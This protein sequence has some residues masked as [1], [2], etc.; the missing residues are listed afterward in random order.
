MLVRDRAKLKFNEGSKMNKRYF[1]AESGHG[2]SSS[3]GFC[4]DTVVYCFTSKQARDEYVANNK[5]ISCKSIPASQATK[6]ATNMSLTC[7][8]TNA[9]RP[10]SGEFWTIRNNEFTGLPV[11]CI[12][13]V[14]CCT[15]GEYGIVERFYK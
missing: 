12:G 13:T 3:R 6:Q 11:G 2:S 5:N 7:N 10:F 14:E 1:T 4:N 8:R 15:D 9:P